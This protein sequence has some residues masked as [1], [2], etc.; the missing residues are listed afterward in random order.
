MKKRG[1]RRSAESGNFL[2][3]AGD[4][5]GKLQVNIKGG[6]GVS[7]DWPQLCRLVRRLNVELTWEYPEEQDLLPAGNTQIT[8]NCEKSSTTKVLTTRQ[9]IR[10][11]LLERILHKEVKDL[12][13]VPM[14]RRLIDI[15]GADYLL[16]QNIYR[17]Y[18]IKDDLVSFW[19]K[20]KHNVLPCNYTLSIWYPG[21]SLACTFNGYRLESMSHILN[22]CKE[23]RN[24]YV[25]RHDRIV[26]KISSEIPRRSQIVVINKTI[27]TCFADTVN[28][29]ESGS[30]QRAPKAF[31]KHV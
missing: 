26:E 4:E 31:E 8:F 10:N 5:S 23:F 21:Q 12:K 16:S 20:A 7:S 11:E 13:E 24:N 15:P 6:F 19:Y 14:Q 9:K 27:Q 28:W 25:T 3:F 30:A 2:G 22:G 29:N 1:V 17:N 18:K